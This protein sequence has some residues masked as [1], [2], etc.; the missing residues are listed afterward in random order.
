MARHA[1]SRTSRDLNRI[2]I[3]VRIDWEGPL[4]SQGS[5][6]QLERVVFRGFLQP[7]SDMTLE[8]LTSRIKNGL[9][10]KDAVVG[11]SATLSCR[12]ALV[13]ELSSTAV[14]QHI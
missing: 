4:L 11:T 2:A 9:F 12:N 6:I 5:T 8:L 13:A 10:S 1:A 3:P 7:T 14:I